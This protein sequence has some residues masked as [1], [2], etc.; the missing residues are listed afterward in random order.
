MNTSQSQTFLSAVTPQQAFA[1][2][3]L[4]KESFEPK[5]E[6][7]K[8]NNKRKRGEEEEAKDVPEIDMVVVSKKLKENFT[9]IRGIKES[10]RNM[11]EDERKMMESLAVKKIKKKV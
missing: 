11:T 7:R 6:S 5:K 3:S 2:F 8:F 1:D 4:E 10:E 9:I